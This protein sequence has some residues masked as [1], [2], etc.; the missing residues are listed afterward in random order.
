M[1]VLLNGQ[2]ISDEYFKEINKTSII[3]DTENNNNEIKEELPS[4]LNI[5]EITVENIPEKLTNEKIYEIFFIFGD[6]S[7]IEFLREQVKINFN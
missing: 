1:Q 5:R 2:E 7:K 6:I 3:Q 4:N